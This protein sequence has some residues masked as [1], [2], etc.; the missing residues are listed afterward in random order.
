MK[1]LIQ[2]FVFFLPQCVLYSQQPDDKQ[3]LITDDG[4]QQGNSWEPKNNVISNIGIQN[5]AYPDIDIVDDDGV[6]GV[7]RNSFFIIFNDGT[8][9][10]SRESSASYGYQNMTDYDAPN[11]VAQ[12]ITGYSITIPSN[13][14]IDYLYLSNIYETDDIEEF[15]DN[16]SSIGNQLHP[17]TI[18]SETNPSRII[19]A[20]HDVVKNKDITL[21]V[22]LRQLKPDTC[23]GVPPTYNLCL[24]I[25]GANGKQFDYSLIELSPVFDGEAFINADI[26]TSNQNN[27]CFENIAFASGQDYAYINLSIPVEIG[28]HRTKNLAFDLIANQSQCNQNANHTEQIRDSHDPNFIEVMCVSR[29]CGYNIVKYHVECENE[30]R[31]PVNNLLMSLTLPYNFTDLSPT[32]AVIGGVNVLGFLLPPNINTANNSVEFNFNHNLNGGKSAYVEFCV[33]YLNMPEGLESANLQPIVPRTDFDG[34]VYAIVE[35][36]DIATPKEIKEEIEGGV[37]FTSSLTRDFTDDC[38]CSY[39]YPDPCKTILIPEVDI[40]LDK[41]VTP[42][43]SPPTPPRVISPVKKN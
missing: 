14:E 25:Q 30:A 31:T 20:N 1:H 26:P 21:I 29:K 11:Y 33:R 27:K 37:V 16:N 39:A 41:P 19:S 43:P 35:F 22:D 17:Y 24:D 9:Y 3:W 5:V 38:N 18:S 34:T 36:R 23:Y 12:P 7:A 42:P 13:K 32:A 28:T 10:N 4:Y 2:V 6:A 15:V 40:D 8:Y